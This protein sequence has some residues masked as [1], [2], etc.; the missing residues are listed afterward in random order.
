MDFKIKLNRFTH[1]T[2]RTL[3]LNAPNILTLLGIAGVGITTYLTAKATTKVNELSSRLIFEEGTEENDKKVAM[4]IAKECAKP[5][6]AAIGTAACIVGANA[7][8]TSR[9]N[10]LA[11]RYNK[12][13]SQFNDYKAAAVAALGGEAKKKIED[14]ISAKKVEESKPAVSSDDDVIFVDMYTKQT[15]QSNLADV[16][17]SMYALNRLLVLNGYASLA[18]YL[19]LLGLPYEKDDKYMGWDIDEIANTYGDL[20]IDFVNEKHEEP[21][22][23]VYYT[24]SMLTEPTLQFGPKTVA[25][26]VEYYNTMDDKNLILGKEAFPFND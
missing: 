5:A 7:I 26:N 16:V 19:D 11:Y 1:K 15:F 24:I 10:G 17:S 6:I 9:I 4:A 3:A 25:L 2:A 22:G 14:Y 20:W 12:T 18:D 8:N 13:V 21:D 23:T